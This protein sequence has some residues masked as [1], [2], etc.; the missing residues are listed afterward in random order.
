MLPFRLSE[1]C[2]KKNKGGVP[3]NEAKAVPIL[4]ERTDV[5]AADGPQLFVDQDDHIIL[6]YNPNF[7]TQKMA[8]SELLFP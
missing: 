7:I 3:L 1:F 2:A 4:Q 5:R 6:F 8:V